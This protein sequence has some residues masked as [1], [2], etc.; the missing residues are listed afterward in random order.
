MPTARTAESSAPV[1]G[2]PHPPVEGASVSGGRREDP[3]LHTRR[4]DTEE[5]GKS[6]GE[7]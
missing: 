4:V 3:D 1:S 7:N 2:I 5:G 6:G